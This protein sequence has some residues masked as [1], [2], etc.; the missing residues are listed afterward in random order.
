M[1]AYLAINATMYTIFALWC[2]IRPRETARFLGMELPGPPALSEY[3]AVY[4]GLEAGMAAFF[5]LGLLKPSLRPAVL[6]FAVC[7]Y[8][9]LV[10]FRTTVVVRHGTAVGNTLGAYGLEI[11]FLVW[12]VVLWKAQAS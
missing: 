2:T 6:L 8:A 10:V 1:T 12:G 4:G 7:L 11:V 3:T 9:G 5:A